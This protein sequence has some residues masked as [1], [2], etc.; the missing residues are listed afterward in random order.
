MVPIGNRTILWH[1]LKLYAD[2]GHRDFIFCLEYKGDVIRDYFLNYRTK[3]NDFTVTL[4]GGGD[5]KFHG[6][7]EVDDW[8]VTCVEIDEATQTVGRLASAAKY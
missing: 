2:E 6:K 8:S 1:I 3:L 7:A 5:V 4:G